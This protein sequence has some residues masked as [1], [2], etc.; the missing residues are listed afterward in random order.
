MEKRLVP[1]VYYGNEY[2]QKKVQMSA[3]QPS[4]GENNNMEDK[5]RGERARTMERNEPCHNSYSCRLPEPCHHLVGDER[6]DWFSHGGALVLVDCGRL[7]ERCWGHSV[8]R[9]SKRCSA[10][11]SGS[12][13]TQP[14]PVAIKGVYG[15]KQA[16]SSRPQQ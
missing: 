16:C 3:M 12:A 15:M 2:K 11:D 8:E 10:P 6:L 14:G 4:A 1:V 9:S 5:E 7:A 13:I